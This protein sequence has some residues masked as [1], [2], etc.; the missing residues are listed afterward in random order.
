[1]AV[2]HKISRATLTFLECCEIV[3]YDY[4]TQ[5]S[6]T[7]PF[8]KGPAFFSRSYSAQTD[9]SLSAECYVLTS[10]ARAALLRAT[11]KCCYRTAAGT[12]CFFWLIAL[13]LE[14]AREACN[15]FFFL[16]G[17]EIWQYKERVDFAMRRS[18]HGKGLLNRG[19]LVCLHDPVWLGQFYKKHLLLT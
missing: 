9:W 14:L 10:L 3:S 8:L 16:V 7:V 11:G 2:K 19:Y 6:I 15:I 1:M 5:I 4:F 13:N 12:T 17:S 18:Y